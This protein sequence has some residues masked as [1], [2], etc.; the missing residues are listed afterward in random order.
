[1]VAGGALTST[2]DKSWSE[3]IASYVLADCHP[4]QL[5][6]VEDP[7]KRITLL[8][9]RGG[10]KTTALR[11]RALLKM[12]RRP[13]AS[14]A[15]VATSRPEAERLNWEPLKQFLTSLSDH[16]P[17]I[18]DDFEFY[19]AK[20]QCVCLRNGSKVT[21]FGVDDKREVNKLRGV[22]FDE[23][24]IDEAASH[25]VLLLE[26]LIDRA[27]G[28]RLGERGGAIVL[29]GTPGHVLRGRFYEAS[30]DG[31]NL[32]RPYS[33][34][35][36]ED[37]ANWIGWSS[38]A[39]DMP[40]I[41]KLPDA[42]KRYPNIVAN[43]KEALVEKQRQGWG[44]DNPIWLREYRGKWAADNTTA[45]YTYR[46]HSADGTPFNRWDPYDG[47]KLEGLVA[48][49]TAIDKLPSDLSDW[50]FG[51]GL[52]L[53]SKDP[54]ALNILAFSPTDAQRR[55]F[56][57]YSFEKRHMYARTIAELLIGTEA[58]EK[59]I[60]S[61]VYDQVG[62][63]FGVTGWPPAIVADLAGLGETLIDELAKVYGIRIKAAE[64]KGKFG[65]IEVVNGDLVDGR[66]F[67]LADSPLEVQLST[68]QW[69]PDEY[70][71]PK[72]D[73]SAANHS[74]DSLTYIRTEI[75]AMFAASL[76]QPAKEEKPQSRREQSKAAKPVPKR[77][78]WDDSPRTS[79]RG[80]EF[81]SLLTDDDLSGLNWGND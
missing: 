19:E 2:T 78:D 4:W 16:I 38:H 37:F 41:L 18:L 9:G 56:H 45:I 61:E 71:Q 35:D 77:D 15:Y 10:G 79:R 70:G 39:W 23:L 44:D 49:K 24:Q 43:W 67:I 51:Y 60:R 13:R 28:P 52:D 72:E 29:A 1:M 73:K 32:H 6:A 69:K 55:F 57:V 34:R 66:M 14:I 8:V 40:D 81:D 42:D 62:G 11:A 27:V 31:S 46:A 22:P 65:A 76:A 74:S 53:G 64:K 30:R 21:F 26:N 48:L 54:F 36:D 75:G 63:L 47:K 59:A 17:G 20:M 7:A 5:A 50:L 80:G 25:D 33:K 68:L 3:E 12:L 58:T